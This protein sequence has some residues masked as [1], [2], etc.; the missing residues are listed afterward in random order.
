MQLASCGCESLQKYGCFSLAIFHQIPSILYTLA[1]P[2]Y[3]LAVR[4]TSKGG[5]YKA[6]AGTMPPFVR[7]FSQ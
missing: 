6:A 2:L 3:N 4:T 5:Q 7:L 1:E